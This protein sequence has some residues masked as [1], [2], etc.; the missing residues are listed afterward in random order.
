MKRSCFDRSLMI[1]FAL[2]C[3]ATL[4]CAK[5][6][7]VH[8]IAAT[9]NKAPPTVVI[10]PGL[11]PAGDDLGYAV[12][13]RM[14]LTDQ[15]MGAAIYCEGQYPTVGRDN[16]NYR[17]AVFKTLDPSHFLL[18]ISNEENR[19]I[20]VAQGQIFM[21]KWRAGTYTQCGFTDAA[22][23]KSHAYFVWGQYR[24]DMERRDGVRYTHCKDLFDLPFPV[25]RALES[26]DDLWTR[27]GIPVEIG[28]LL[29]YNK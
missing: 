27:Y 24:L 13:M 8:A 19:V 10:F 21:V 26:I 15:P 16:E 18:S 14:P 20:E 6:Y 29:R 7:T 4:G 5:S 9:D 22:P 1:L 25:P 12:S 28:S 23:R 11:Y 2:V 17:A 3:L